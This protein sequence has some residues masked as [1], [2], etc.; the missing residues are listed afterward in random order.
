LIA[1]VAWDRSKAA[2]QAREC[3]ARWGRYTPL[4]A[5]NWKAQS[6]MMTQLRD[7]REWKSRTRQTAAEKSE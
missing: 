2:R 6:S 4:T 1:Q 3:L 7:R 5:E